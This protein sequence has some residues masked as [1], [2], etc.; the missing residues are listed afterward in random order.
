MKNILF[1][2]VTMPIG[3]AEMLCLNFVKNLDP[4][5]F[6]PIVC[7]IADKGVIG[8][9]LE[10]S[11]FEV[12]A[13]DRMQSKRFDRSAVTALAQ[14]IKAR[15]ID[16]VHTN[17]YH[18]SLYGRLAVL[19]AGKP[20]P[21]VVAAVHSLYTERKPHRIRINRLLNRFTTRIIAVSD[22]VRSDIVRFEGVR[23]EKVSVLPVGADFNRLDVPL[24]KKEAKERLG[25]N[26]SDFVLGTVGRL[27][28][29]KGH[30]YL[31]QTMSILKQSGRDFKLIIA[32]GGRLESDLR[33]TAASLGIDGDVQFLGIR[34]DVPE[35]YRAMDIYLMSSVSEA[36]SLA[37]LEAMASGL[38]CVVTSVGGMVD[39]IGNDQ[40]GLIVPPRDPQSMADA[41]LSLRSSPERMVCIGEHAKERAR[42]LYSNEAMI[43]QLECI[44]EGLFNE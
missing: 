30:E 25:F 41:V 27:V 21:K 23:P 35:L 4:E 9:A 11:G 5:K 38:P 7:C 1:V 28:D 43:S 17:M 6:K 24:T 2:F 10:S 14:L 22:A 33:R 37:L 44:Y 8:E 32:G 36:A 34:D 39:L 29:A 12:I 13:L 3:G 42:S 26:E 16:I 19:W 18:A 31:L 20:R 40:C 15:K